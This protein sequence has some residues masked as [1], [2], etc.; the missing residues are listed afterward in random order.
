MKIE[1][2]AYLAGL[3][4]GEGCISIF[5]RSDS[6]S[7]KATLTIAMTD[8][9]PL[10]WASETFGAKVYEKRVTGAA[11]NGWKQC[12]V[13]L[14]STQKAAEILRNVLPFLKVK[15]EQAALLVELADIRERHRAEGTRNGPH[16][17]HRQ[18][19]IMAEVQRLNR[20]GAV[21]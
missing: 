4:D 17:Q 13:W 19:A 11:E 18:L 16:E 7:L 15:R 10:D 3:I 21:S 8:R 20:K 12:Y 2:L 6:N 1:D 5:Q 14:V 9:A